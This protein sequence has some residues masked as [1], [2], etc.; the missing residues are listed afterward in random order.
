MGEGGDGVER[1]LK[2]ACDDLEAVRERLAD[3]GA[4]RQAAAAFEDNLVFDRDGELESIGG[5]LRLR[6]DRRGARLTVKGPPRFEDGVKLRGEREIS[7]SDPAETEAL[8]E[9]LGYSVV[10]RYQK[11]REEWQLGGVV[12]ALD[13]TP[14]GDFVEFEGEKAAPVARRCGFEIESAER[15]SYLRIYADHLSENPEAPPQMVFP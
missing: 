13:H 5:V 1:E 7:V 14:V 2:F 15:R 11:M 3:L 10:Q 12:A 6:S 9:M 8:L 4:E